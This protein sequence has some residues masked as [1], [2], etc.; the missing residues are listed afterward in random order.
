MVEVLFVYKGSRRA[1]FFQV[2]AVCDRVEQEL[3]DLGVNEPTV[4]LSAGLAKPENKNLNCFFLQRWCH[5]WETF[6]NVEN[7][8]EIYSNDR[9]T[10]VRKHTSSPIKVCPYISKIKYGT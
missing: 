5:K 9:L 1:L 8:Q 4:N 6:I 2:S 10:V 3:Q 7:V